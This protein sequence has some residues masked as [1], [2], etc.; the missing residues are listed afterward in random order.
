MMRADRISLESLLQ[1]SGKS[2]ILLQTVQRIRDGAV[3][4]YPTD[5]IY[6][7]GGIVREDVEK[8]ILAVKKRPPENPMILLAGSKGD[9]EFLDLS[10]PHDAEVLAKKF[11]PG[12]L[13][14]VLKSNYLGCSTGV[15]IS[16]HPFPALISPLLRQPVY[17]TSANISGEPYD[18]DPDTIFSTFSNTVD[19]MIDAGNLPASRPSTVVSFDRNGKVQIIRE[20]VVSA[21]DICNITG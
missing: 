17:S 13:T 6:G 3:F 12:N 5:T 1:G 16:S 15:R 18:P 10:I 8:K 14:L 20:G 19:F 2:E 11:W 9:L 7:I 4:V 21:L